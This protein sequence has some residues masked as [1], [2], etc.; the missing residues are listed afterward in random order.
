[1]LCQQFDAL[2]RWFKSTSFTLKQ[3]PNQHDFD[4]HPH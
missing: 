1:M 2:A 3:S 4:L